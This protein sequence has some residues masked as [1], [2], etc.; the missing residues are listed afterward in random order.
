M[1]TNLLLIAALATGCHAKFKKAVPYID[2]INVQV[3]TSGGPYVELGKI[4][5]SVE[6]GDQGANLLADIAVAAV[7]ISQDVKGINQTERIANAVDIQD[8]NAYMAMGLA[9]TLGGGPPFAYTESDAD[10]T[11]QLEVLSYGVSVPY[12]GAPGEFTYS[13]NAR[14][15]TA[16]G[17]RVYRKGLTCTVGLGNPEAAAVVFGTVNNIKQLDEMTDAEINDAF[18]NAAAWCGQRFVLKM[19]QHAG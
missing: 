12:L 19:R 4:Y 9:D 14:M 8:V 17:E 2:D 6:T 10:A 1:R 7:N 15:Y 5:S 3:V 18:R 13:V 11:L 16:A